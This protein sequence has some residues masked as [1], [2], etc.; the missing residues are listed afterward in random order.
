MAEKLRGPFD[1]F[2]DWW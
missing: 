1:K 2:V